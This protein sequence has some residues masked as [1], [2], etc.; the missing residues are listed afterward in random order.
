MAAGAL[1]T[2]RGATVQPDGTTVVSLDCYVG[3]AGAGGG[4]VQAEATVLPADS[5]Q[6]VN[7]KLVT[8]AVNG[9]G[10]AGHTLIAR[11]VLIQSFARG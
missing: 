1:V 5:V 6:V 4:L 11:D 3:G 10:A 2:I 7:S 9:M 8:A